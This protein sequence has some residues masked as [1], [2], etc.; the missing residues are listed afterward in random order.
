MLEVAKQ[1]KKVLIAGG[2]VAGME[3]ARFSAIEG[4]EVASFEKAEKSGVT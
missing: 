4:H 3:A 2:G 1:P